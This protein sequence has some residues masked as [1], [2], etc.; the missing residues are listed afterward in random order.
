MQITLRR[1]LAA[2]AAAIAVL[3]AACAA[4]TAATGPSP[5]AEGT[6]DLTGQYRAT[7]MDVGNVLPRTNAERLT[8]W[9]DRLTPEDEVARL[10]DLQQGTRQEALREELFDHEVGR[11]R[12]GQGLSYPIAAALAFEGRDGLRH[13]V[14]VIARPISFG[15]IFTAS[16]SIDYPFS[17][18]ELDL[19]EDGGG[20][21]ELN[22]A[23]RFS[24]TADRRVVVDDLAV[25]PL[26]ILDVERVAR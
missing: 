20:S 13:L 9:V 7:L 11:L 5:A 23:A 21:G 3:M 15:E 25:R 12:V 1:S 22:V 26:R 18:I 8:I 14:L 17:V 2:A 4:G 16:R 19:G 10:A 6:A 24:L